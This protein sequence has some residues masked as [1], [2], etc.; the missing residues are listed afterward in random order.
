MKKKSA[1]IPHF[2]NNVIFYACPYC[3]PDKRARLKEDKNFHVPCDHKKG[4][5]DKKKECRK[6]NFECKKVLKCMKCK[7][8]FS[9]SKDFLKK[10]KRK[11]KD[12]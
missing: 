1:E 7:E 3:R 9:Y 12:G 4:F 11:Y 5:F 6:D 2:H 10:Q 8:T